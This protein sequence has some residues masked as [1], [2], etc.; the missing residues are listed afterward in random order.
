MP[1]TATHSF[2][3]KDVYD[4]LPDK[5]CEQLDLEKSKMYGQGIDS[6]KFYNL[7]SIFPGKKMRH[8]QGYFHE[9]QSQEFFLNLLKYMKDNHIQDKDTYSYLFGNI[10]HYAVDSTVHPY[11]VYR[12]GKFEKDKP[13]TYKYNNVHAF[14][15]T[16]I[17]NDMIQRRM[18][19]N[20]YR[21]NFSDFCFDI[22]PFSNDLE[23]TIDYTF[24][25]TFQMA[26]MSK[27]YYKSLKQMRYSI[28][29][30]RKDRFR[31]KKFFYKLADTFTPRSWFRFEAISYHYPLEDTHNYLNSDHTLWR[32]PCVYDKTSTESFVDLYLKAIKLAKVLTCASF[33]YLNDKNIDLEKIFDNTSYVTGLNC[34][35]K[36]ELKYF[37]F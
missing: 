36:K 19:M 6:L 21:F 12:T 17:D 25:N 35:D 7:F 13:S 8:F 14:M 22:S 11:V 2:F 28:R 1:A 20:P 26:D 4:I 33:D 31:I 23:K 3:V 10:C 5:V 29:I 16:F 9:N 34:N 15:E 27:V 24:Y 32:N 18:N 37:E 30:F